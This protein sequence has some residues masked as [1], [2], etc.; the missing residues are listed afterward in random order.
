VGDLLVY[1]SIMM[2]TS[3]KIDH[4]LKSWV[5]LFEPIARGEKTHDFRVQDRDYKVGDICLLREYEPTKKEYTGRQ[6]L[7]E[8]TYIT[9]AKHVECAFSPFAMHPAMAILSIKT[10]ATDN[11]TL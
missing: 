9:S 4:E 3:H 8:I 5:G 2:M 10:L 7:I 6:C 11:H 1:N